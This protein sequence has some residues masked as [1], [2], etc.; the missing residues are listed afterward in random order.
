MRAMGVTSNADI[1]HNI[2]GLRQLLFKVGLS[3]TGP[4]QK[5]A[6]KRLI[7]LLEK[8]RSYYFSLPLSEEVIKAYQSPKN[9]KKMISKMNY[10]LNIVEKELNLKKGSKS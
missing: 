2:N 3:T 4:S 7:E 1:T 10:F 9:K 6:K 8:G 5:W